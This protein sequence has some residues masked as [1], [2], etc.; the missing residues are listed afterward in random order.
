MDHK[1]G[2]DPA[3]CEQQDDPPLLN[4]DFDLCGDYRHRIVYKSNLTPDTYTPTGQILVHENNVFFDTPGDAAFVDAHSNEHDDTDVNIEA[5]T[6]RCVFRANA[7]RY[8]CSGNTDPDV[9]TCPSHH[10][11]RKVLEAPRDYDALRPRFTWLPTDII[12]K[13]FK[14]TTQYAQMP[15]N[16]ILR[17]CF[18]S[19]NPAVNVS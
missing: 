6:D 19:P 7:H 4:S 16:T 18:K 1:Q 12:K 11:P 9:H 8:V 13:T 10:R 3:W 15:L 14:V 17:K 2:D 5:A